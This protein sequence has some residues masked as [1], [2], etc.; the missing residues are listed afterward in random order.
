MKC[1][2]KR[3][4]PT[5]YEKNVFSIALPRLY[6][7][8]YRYLFIDLDNTLAAYYE[9]EPS[10]LTRSFLQ[11]CDHAG[12]MVTITSNNKDQRVA[13]FAKACGVPYLANLGKPFSRQILKFCEE[14]AYAKDKVM[15]IGDQLLTDVWFAN[16]LGF[17]SIFVE[18]LVKVDHWPTSIN[19][20]FERPIK[21]YLSQKGLL[22]PVEDHHE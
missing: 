21:R 8:G 7:L 22:K 2:K 10:A 3:F 16:R 9:M 15:V 6:Q 11:A 1:I 5:F 20:W 18:K 14:K 17:A 12:L 19:R 4:A 13:P